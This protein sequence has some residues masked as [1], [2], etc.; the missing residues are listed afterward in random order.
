MTESDI[1]MSHSICFGDLLKDSIIQ[2]TILMRNYIVLHLFDNSLISYKLTDNF[3]ELNMNTKRYSL[4]QDILC[5]CS[6]T[7]LNKCFCITEKGKTTK[8]LDLHKN[9]QLFL[10]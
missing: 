7:N 8:F 10:E 1:Y 2:K 9:P 6:D 3:Q 4:C 5:L